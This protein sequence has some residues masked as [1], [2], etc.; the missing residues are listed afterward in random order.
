M[1]IKRFHGVSLDDESAEILR[2]FGDG[3]LSAGIRKAAKERVQLSG[4]V[5]PELRAKVAAQLARIDA[6]LGI[7]EPADARLYTAAQRAAIDG[8]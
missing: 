2:A 6:H 4:A 5:T 7:P 8:E 1:G 3:N